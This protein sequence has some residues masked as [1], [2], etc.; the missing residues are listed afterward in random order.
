MSVIM[1]SVIILRVTA[2]HLRLAQTLPANIRVGWKWQRAANT[3]AHCAKVLITMV[4]IFIEESLDLIWTDIIA[5]NYFCG[6]LTLQTVSPGSNKERLSCTRS[7]ADWR[8]PQKKIPNR[9]WCFWTFSPPVL[10]NDEFETSGC[11]N[12]IFILRN[13]NPFRNKLA[14]FHNLRLI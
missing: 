2:S 13:L 11:N 14:R 5:I 4:K 9:Y 6:I 7:F 10:K 1:L 3:L 8:A 12:K